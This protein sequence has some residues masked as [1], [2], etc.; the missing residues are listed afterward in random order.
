MSMYN[1]LLKTYRRDCWP[2]A[3]VEKP[4]ENAGC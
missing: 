4:K 2:G 1:T 3:P